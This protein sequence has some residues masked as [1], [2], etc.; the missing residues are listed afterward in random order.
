M[1]LTNHSVVLSTKVWQYHTWFLF[2]MVYVIMCAFIPALFSGTTLLNVAIQGT[3]VT[4]LAIGMAFVMLVGE[5]DL[6]NAAIA[7]FAPMM[8]V[9]IMEKIGLPVPLAILLMV[10]I[11]MGIGAFNGLLI[12]RVKVPSLVQTITTQWMLL[13]ILLLITRGHAKTGLPKSWMWPG[14]TFVGP[15]PVLFFIFVAI[16]VCAIFFAIR[17]VT[18]KRIYLV[19]GSREACRAMGIPVGKII[20][21]SFILSGFFAALAGY[22]LSTRMG[23][24]SPKFA[25]EWLM[26][27]IAAPVIAGVSLTGGRGNLINV[28]AGAYLVQVIVIIVTAGGVGGYAYQFIQ[29]LLVFVALLMDVARKRFMKE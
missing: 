5:I 12:T 4:L 28:V 22:L 17:T 15:F 29:G 21:I 11:G 3:T 26:P 19:G 7:A 13:G 8:A 18:G 24:I 20:T 23:F 6:S 9:M 14:R 1:E 16:V 2:V 25:S 27:A 10:L